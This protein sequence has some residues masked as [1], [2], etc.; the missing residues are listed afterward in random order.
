MTGAPATFG[1]PW[2]RSTWPAPS[3]T[4]RSDDGQELGDLHWTP[5]G[6]TVVFVRGGDENGHGENPNPTHAPAGVEQ[7]IWTV[8]VA[9]GAPRRIGVGSG[10]AIS[11]KGDR[12]AF[13]RHG[14][15]W[16]ASLTD[17][18]PAEQVIHARGSAGELRWSPDG[19]HLAFVSSRGDHAFIGVYDVAAKTLAFVDPSVDSDAEPVWSPDGK[20]V[21]FV[22]IPAAVG[23]LPFVPQRSAQ[24]WSIRVVDVAT[25]VGRQAWISDSGRGSAFR[26]IVADNQLFWEGDRL[27]FPWERDGW[28]H[29][30]SVPVAGGSATLLTP[31]DFEVE[32]AAASG[33]RTGV[34][35]NSN[36]GDID[37]R[38]LWRAAA[39]G[40]PPVALTSGSGIEWAP[41]P[42]AGRQSGGVPALRC[43]AASP[44][45]AP[46]G[47]GG[48]RSGHG[49]HPR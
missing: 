30:Y 9:G 7:A 10:P 40:G 22:R 21:A 6:H 16:W 39:T 36:Q 46:R 33:D 43:T 20:S 44:S 38:H 18:M 27:V 23:V 26:G 42:T 47:G 8:A 12:V 49:R 25:G 35:F 5:D 28:T 13:I 37:R 1:S 48:A 34:V 4:T 29:L 15:V 24:P 32:F 19:S 31:G 45:G 2:P 41:A 14:Q 11:P 17:T 3:P